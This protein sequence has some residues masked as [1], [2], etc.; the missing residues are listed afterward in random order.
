MVERQFEAV[1]LTIFDCQWCGKPLPKGRAD[2][3]THKQCRSKLWRWKKKQER[4]AKNAVNLINHIADNSSLMFYREE[5]ISQLK[6]IS[7]A[8]GRAYAKHNIRKVS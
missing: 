2:M 5:S 8:L 7:A 6:A 4:M 3:K 1:Q